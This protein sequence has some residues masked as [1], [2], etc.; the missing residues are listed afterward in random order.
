MGL[1]CLGTMPCLSIMVGG[2][3][4]SCF[5]KAHTQPFYQKG[6][7]QDSTTNH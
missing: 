1:G 7:S 2:L 6:G 3:H 5:F 4:A